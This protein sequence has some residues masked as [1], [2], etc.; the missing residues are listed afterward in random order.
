MA[1]W[2][3]HGIVLA[4]ILLIAVTAFLLLPP[5]VRHGRV[6]DEVSGRVASGVEIT[7]DKLK[8]QRFSH[9]EF[10]IPAHL[11]QS[12]KL[13]FSAPGYV[14]QT[15]DLQEVSWPVDVRLKPVDIPHL[16]GIAA[17][18]KL[19]GEQLTFD[20]QLLNANGQVMGEYPGVDLVAHVIIADVD[21]KESGRATMPLVRND[22]GQ[23]IALSGAV[24]LI[25]LREAAGRNPATFSVQL[26]AGSRTVK[27]R[28]FSAPP[29]LEAAAEQVQ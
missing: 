8:L 17:F 27:S 24:S 4:G 7:S 18:P 9:Q 5:G 29:G 11:A 12:G 2:L 21:G 28:A 15:I 10:S 25:A 19:I 16:G 22:S 26:M 6:L 23:S 20:L 3:Q 13:T 1:R 14:P